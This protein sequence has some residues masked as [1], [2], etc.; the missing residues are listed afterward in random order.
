MPDFNFYPEK[1]LKELLSVLDEPL[2]DM[3]IGRLIHELYNVR[4]DLIGVLWTVD[5]DGKVV[6]R[7]DE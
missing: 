4:M 2:P 5:D 7:R 3:T 6:P 1:H